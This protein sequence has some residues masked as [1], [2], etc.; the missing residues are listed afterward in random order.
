MADIEAENQLKD[1][2][3]A[4]LNIVQTTVGQVKSRHIPENH[5]TTGVNVA[6]PPSDINIHAFSV[7]RWEEELM[8]GIKR[9]LEQLLQEQLNQLKS[10]CRTY[11]VDLLNQ[12]N[13][14]DG[15]KEFTEV[16]NIGMLNPFAREL[17]SV[18]DSIEAYQAAWNGNA[19]K[20]GEFIKNYP[21]MKDKSGLWGTTLLYSA[22]RNNR[23]NL[24][25]QLIDTHQC[26]VDA[27]NQQH[28]LGA[29]AASGHGPGYYDTNTKAGSTALHG[30][31]FAGH[32]EV[33]QSLI[34]H[35]ANYYIKNQGGET[36]LAH[37]LLHQHIFDYFRELVVLGYSSKSDILPE[38]PIHDN[39]GSQKPDCVWEYKPFA[40]EKW[41]NFSLP[42]CETLQQA[43]KLQPDKDFHREIYLKVPKGIY[44]VKLMNFL[45]SGRDLNYAENLAWVRCRGS[46]LFNF[47]CYALWQIF[48]TKHPDGLEDPI[49]NAINL[50]TSYDSRFEIHLRTWYFCDAQTTQQLEKAM[51]Y[52]RKIS[53]IKVPWISENALKSN[54]ENFTFIDEQ[55]A[56]TGFLR[57]V[58]K[59]ISSNSRHQDEIAGMD[60]YATMANLNPIPLTTS[61]L[62]QVSEVKDN[63]S[64]ENEEEL[65]EHMD[66]EDF[67]YENTAN[68]NNDEDEPIDKVDKKRRKLFCDLILFL[69]SGYSY[70]RHTI[71][72]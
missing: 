49:F 45:R 59:M 15:K 50:P 47:S 17:Q 36:P 69:D 31:C 3:E 21:D 32:L 10:Y 64:T 57:W 1:C 53:S 46:S 19:T 28:I 7:D 5:A 9:D 20:V 11:F 62:K 37:A 30:A 63:L 56:I 71:F 8:D 51:K 48:L 60:E 12:F 70:Q 72:N 35:G 26:S 55:E 6:E 18:L 2:L 39:A 33:V 58:P 25:N 34:T 4:V 52:R 24:V 13:Y 41:Y 54:M 23:L 22:A 29:L 61:R 67:S 65:A 68:R 66:D 38:E 42:E 27:Q 40:D 16:F 14:N 44:G 43:L